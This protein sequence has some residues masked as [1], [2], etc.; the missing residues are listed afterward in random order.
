VKQISFRLKAL[1]PFR[2]DF[3]VWVLRRRME[4]TWDRWDGETYR[5]VLVVQGRPVDIAV[6]QTGP[7]DNPELKVS[8]TGIR[9]NTGMEESLNVILGRVLGLQTDLTE[10]Y[11]LA[12]KDSRLKSLASKFRGMKPPRYPSVFEALV[13]AIT[14]QQF[15]LTA[16]IRLLSRLV[17][18]WGLPFAD[19]KH[20]ER[21]FP[22][23]QDLAAL[24]VEDF[25]KLGFSR[26]KAQSI[27]D[28]SRIAVNE[29]KDLE[30]LA[31]FNDEAVLENL[32]RIRGVGRW[33]A[34][35]VLLRGLGRTHIFPGDDVG[36]R[37]KLQS[38]LK[39]SKPLDYE[40]VGR[41]LNRW[42]PYGGLVYFLLLLNSLAE[43]GLVETEENRHQTSDTRLQT[44]DKSE[45]QR[46][47]D[48]GLQASDEKITTESTE[49]TRP[50][51]SDQKLTTEDTEMMK[52]DIRLQTS[53]QKPTTESTE[54]S[55]K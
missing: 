19:D 3:T 22:R 29:G 8:A 35:Y 12:G 21:A 24:E 30:E 51:T 45:P 43:Q 42:K 18:T 55:Q 53:D 4:N 11:R 48:I 41:I 16:G 9:L 27:I 49:K 36:V 23:P 2:L 31:A 1:P 25:K 6:A 17:G 44:S 15:T 47:S 54:S 5:R 26:Q 46:T 39:V 52:I 14:C 7:P 13:N 37:N 38:W 40:G 33:T 34:E 10:L 50:Q 20:H 28:L 32:T